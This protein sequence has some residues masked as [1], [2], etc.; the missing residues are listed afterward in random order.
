MVR[1][2]TSYTPL[3]SSRCTSC[4][5]YAHQSTKPPSLRL[6]RTDPTFRPPFPFHSQFIWIILLTPFFSLP[7]LIICVLGGFIGQLY[8]HAQLAVKRELSNRKSPVF[9]HFGAA[10]AGIVTIR[11]FGAQKRFADEALRRIDLY[12]RPSEMC[13]WAT[14]GKEDG[15]SCAR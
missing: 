11:A 12:S 7:G 10:I 15:L 4:L 9:S 14:S 3:S 13:K 5:G 6:L 8:I 1:C 2:L